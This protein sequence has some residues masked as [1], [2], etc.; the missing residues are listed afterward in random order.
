MS[1]AASRFL[2]PDQVRD[3]LREA[4]RR[5]KSR[6]PDIEAVYLFGSF[7]AGVPTPRS[8]ADVL[9]VAGKSRWEDLY[10]D[11]LSVPVPVDLHLVKPDVFRKLA[12]SGKGVAGTAVRTGLRLL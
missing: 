2:I 10:P 11:F 3:A 8:D 4:V 5:L 7:A 1:F 6:C 12:A 9:V